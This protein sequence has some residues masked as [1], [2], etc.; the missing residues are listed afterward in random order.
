MGQISLHI[1][2]S[3]PERGSWI[4]SAERGGHVH[5]LTRVIERLVGMLPEANQLDHQLHDE[6]EQPPKAPFGKDE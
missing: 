6:N 1:N 5:A 3:F 4:T 2:G